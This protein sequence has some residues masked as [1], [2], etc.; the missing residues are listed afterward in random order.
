LAQD[1]VPGDIV[2]LGQGDRVPAD[3]RILEAASFFV[4]EA[5]LTGESEPVGKQVDD[6]VYMGTIVVS[7]R[8][9]FE[10]VKIGPQTKIGEIAQ[11]LKT[12]EQPETT[13]QLR[14][15]K[16]DIRF[17]LDSNAVVLFTFYRGV[18]Y[19][20]RTFGNGGIIYGYLCGYNS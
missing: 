1:L 19:R 5:I 8:T 18:V 20:T 7:G 2:F 3:G 10:V 15:K 14:L 6:A 16:N 12:T 13:L 9:V 4:N 11:T 17:D